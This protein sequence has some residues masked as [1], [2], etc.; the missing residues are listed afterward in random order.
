MAILPNIT[1]PA[2][3]RQLKPEQLTLL[4]AELR[5]FVLEKTKEKA[6][7]IKS[8]FG[9][10]E[11]TVA[12][13]FAYNTPIDILIWDVGHQ[14][15][16]HKIITDRK[17]RFHTNRQFR[18]ISGFTNRA[19]SEYDPF[20]AGHSS[21]ALS[22]L[23]GF[24]EAAKLSNINRQH[25]AVV[26]DGAF[27]GGLHFEA[28]NYAGDRQLDVTLI[29]NNNNASIDANV[30]AIQRLHSYKNLCASLGFSFLGEVDGHNPTALLKA[31]AEAQQ[32]KGP[33]AILVQ[34]IKGKGYV[35]PTKTEIGSK[36]TFQSTLGTA[37]CSMA[38][39]NEKLVVVSPAMLSGAGL[40]DF[41]AKFPRRCFDVG[42]A[43]QQ[44]VT[45]SAALAAE[46]FTVFCHLYSTFA[47]RAYDQLI[48][49][50]ALQKLPVIFLLDRAGL[51]GEDG[52][53]HHGAFDLSF[54]NPIPNM[55]VSAAADTDS[56]TQLLALAAE[57]KTGPMSIRYPKGSC[58]VLGTAS[59]K[60]GFGRWIK[61]EGGKLVIS[62]G[63]LQESQ[64]TAIS[65]SGAAHYDWVFLK[66]FNEALALEITQNFEHI[67]TIEEGSAAGGLGH[68]FAAL[69]AKN[70]ISK[71]LTC[72]TLP[73]VFV[74][75]G[76][77]AE[78]LN[79]I[80]LNGGF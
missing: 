68:V 63:A 7:H 77:D 35:A 8:S 44:A 79:Y 34:T 16:I 42:I 30:G 75:H 10:T 78:L 24:A 57:H 51:V 17:H 50:V 25:I 62:I 4:C 71:K 38:E 65:K 46:G 20:G 11:L 26:G 72:L 13:H 27:T 2:D 67:I 59:V 76:S 3:L 69:F 60:F 64:V 12:L 19:E 55:V 29:I 36:E 47:Q 73:D 22:A 39:K 28:M 9:V 23:T 52:A 32:I 1:S 58:K 14:A 61:K 33:K 41:K 40:T 48:H 43:E 45:M 53:T 70:T 6:G 21:T 56:L 74:P 66:P 80:G 18:G 31:F 5:A 49:D 37:L 54:L 15:Y